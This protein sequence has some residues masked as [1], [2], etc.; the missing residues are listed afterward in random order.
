[1]SMISF[2]GMGI[3]RNKK[4]LPGIQLTVKNLQLDHLDIVHSPFSYIDSLQIKDTWKEY[5]VFD[6]INPCQQ[7]RPQQ[8]RR[9]SL[10]GKRRKRRLKRRQKIREL[11]A[12]VTL[13]ET[14]ETPKETLKKAPKES[15]AQTAYI[16]MLCV[17][18]AIESMPVRTNCCFAPGPVKDGCTATARVLLQRPTRLF[19]KAPLPFTASPVTKSTCKR[20]WRHFR[21]P[22]KNSGRRFP[23]SRRRPPERS[24]HSVRQKREAKTLPLSV[25]WIF[26]RKVMHQQPPRVVS[27]VLIL[28]LL[29]V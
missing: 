24:H 12:T 29:L 9:P 26:S 4:V 20:S 28:L 21:A 7:R 1:M 17:F 25:L 18:A 3:T 22:F 2:S 19:V 13:K 8:G 16:V 15:T 23:S 14:K 5:A 27:E 10:C 6:D 11:T